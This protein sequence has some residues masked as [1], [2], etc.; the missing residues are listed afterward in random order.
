MPGVD[1]ATI[2]ADGEGNVLVFWHV[3]DPPQEDVPDGHWIYLSRSTDQGTHFAKAERVRIANVK[4]L[5]CSMC[6]RYFSCGKS[7]R[8]LLRNG[9]P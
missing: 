4:D 3:F 8:C 5:A 6:M 2:A 9:R 1:G 7:G